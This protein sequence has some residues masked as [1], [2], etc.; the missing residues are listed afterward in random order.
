MTTL[1]GRA[2]AKLNLTLEV[3]G[4]RPDGYHE[5][6]SVMHTLELYDTLT[7]ELPP[8]ERFDP[9]RGAIRIA[10]DGAPAHEAIPTDSRNLVWQ[11]VARFAETCDALTP[12]VPLSRVAGEGEVSSPLPQRGRGAG[13]EGL[14]SWRAIL[15]K[16]IPSQ[17]GLGGGSSDAALALKLLNQ[18]AARW[19]CA[20]SDERLHALARA[21]GA[22]VAFFLR[23][24]CALA[25]GMGEQLQPLL[26]LPS[27]WWVVTKPHAVGVPT[28]WAYAQLKRGDYS[29]AVRP[30]H[31]E[32]LLHALPTIR[33]PDQ[34][35]PLLH[36]DFDAPIL[37]AVPAL[38]QVRRLMERA[39]A[40]R[41]ILC[42]SGAAQAALCE[43]EYH[44]QTL[45]K[46]LS[47]QNYWAIATRNC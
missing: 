37:E 31:T 3:L 46:T 36:N 21:L 18:W 19:D 7:L 30:I 34:L 1:E 35:A 24:G 15:T 2:P 40:R 45:A 28:G 16:R 42:G 47:Q 43:S 44:A 10:G 23:G 13:G 14:L 17:A 33:T 22:D 38:Q 29:D 6:A 27:F 4:R 32:R 9:V 25:R 41:V 26:T 20:L 8:P 5:V 11:A 12:S 39:G